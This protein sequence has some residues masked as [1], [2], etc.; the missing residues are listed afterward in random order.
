MLMC[1]L[2]QRVPVL[3]RLGIY[4]HVQTRPECS[5]GQVLHGLGSGRGRCTQGGPSWIGP[6]ALLSGRLG[7]AFPEVEGISYFASALRPPPATPD[8][9]LAPVGYVITCNHTPDTPSK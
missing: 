1:S 7:Q 9:S 8:Q 3:W 6:G 5:T 4:R 2:P